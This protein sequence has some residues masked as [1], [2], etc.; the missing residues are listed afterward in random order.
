MSP[1]S[2]GV[3]DYFLDEFHAN[4]L[5]S[6]WQELGFENSLKVT[7]AF[8]EVDKPGG[9][10]NEN[11]CRE[12]GVQLSHS[13][14]DLVESVGAILVLA[15]S[16][17]ELHARYS[18]AALRSGKP[19]FIDKIM[20]PDRNT[21]RM[22]FELAE[23]HGTPCFS[24]S[25]LLWA[26]VVEQVRSEFSPDS[27]RRLS[28]GSGGSLEEYSVHSLEM[29]IALKQDVPK[30]ILCPVNSSEPTILMEYADE[31]LVTMEI[32]KGAPYRLSVSS[33]DGRSLHQ[34]EIPLTFF[35]RFVT[36]L[37]QF[38]LDG[39]TPVDSIHTLKVLACYEAALLA[40]ATAGTWVD[41][42]S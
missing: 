20:A 1:R 17:P 14:D 27:I 8:A 25:A 9:V 42:P 40:R 35:D 36:S 39:V 23:K 32:V 7:H 34:P 18:E 37:A 19:V 22:M 21:G 6:R 33:A 15:P 29:L 10:S 4:F 26:E 2:V 5:P 13:L 41:V 11:W 30:R 24:A 12:R 38:L 28:L 3:I 16:N 31:S